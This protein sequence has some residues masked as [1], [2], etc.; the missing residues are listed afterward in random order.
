MNLLSD[1]GAT[2]YNLCY[3]WSN[4]EI[5]DMDFW[6]GLAYTAYLDFLRVPASIFAP[7]TIEIDW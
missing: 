1:D 7:G 3:F 5:A 2:Y 4:F 6:R